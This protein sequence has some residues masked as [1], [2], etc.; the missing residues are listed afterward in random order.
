ME[1]MDVDKTLKNIRNSI[2]EIDTCLP[3]L[4]LDSSVSDD[5]LMVI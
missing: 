1:K 5:N 3:K 2:S 4:N